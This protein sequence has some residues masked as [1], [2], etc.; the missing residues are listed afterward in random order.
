MRVSKH[1]ISRPT[2]RPTSRPNRS[3][4]SRHSF[5]ALLVAATFCPL[6][7]AQP[8]SEPP[9]SATPSSSTPS[10]ST[11]ERT[12]TER[13][14]TIRE[15]EETVVQ[16]QLADRPVTV[17]I[18]VKNRDSDIPA[19]RVAVF[20]DYL[21]ARL[22]DDGF[23]IIRREEVL[24]S[25]KDFAADGPNRGSDALPGASMDQ[26]LSNNTSALR[27]AQNLGAD[28]LLTATLASLDVDE[29]ESAIPGGVVRST[30]TNLSAGY[31]ML[32]AADGTTFKGD[33]SEAQSRSTSTSGKPAR[34]NLDAL[35]RESANRMAASI[36]ADVARRLPA[37][38]AATAEVPVG[39]TVRVANFNVPE[40]TRTPDG[41]YSIGESKR[42]EVQ[43]VNVFVDGIQIGTTSAESGDL[44]IAP[45][46]HKLR[47][48]RAGFNDYEATVKITPGIQLNIDMQ[49][50]PAEE[51]RMLQRAVVFDSLK[52]RGKLTDAEVKALEGFAKMLSESFLRYDTGGITS[53]KS[54]TTT[55]TEINTKPSG[56]DP[57]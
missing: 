24:N 40:V 13:V 15:R 49:M 11:S 16:R 22:A 31:T 18:F 42:L 46:I 52:N 47:L 26:L 3:L 27:L 1:M 29:A 32:N 45:G 34:A 39:I 50:T 8:A 14:T 48:T 41:Q 4:L 2:T 38:A 51:A 30:V 19:D 33:F 9:A 5:A 7:S 28:L 25:V 21:T 10:S 35:L 36:K 12:I 20:E 57:R 43:N 56:N 6:V 55:K 23:K 54:E 44:R 53:Y 17:A 37:I